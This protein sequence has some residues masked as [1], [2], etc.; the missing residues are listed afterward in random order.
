MRWSTGPG[1]AAA[2][3]A[4]APASAY[5][6]DRLRGTTAATRLSC[7]T[8]AAHIWSHRFVMD[9]MNF[10]MSSFLFYSTTRVT[11]ACVQISGLHDEAHWVRTRPGGWLS[12]H[13]ENQLEATGRVSS[14]DFF[15]LPKNNHKN[16]TP[17]HSSIMS[18]QMFVLRLTHLGSNPSWL[19]PRH[20]PPPAPA[21]VSA[22]HPSAPPPPFPPPTRTSRHLCSAVSWLR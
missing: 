3:C 4:P 9:R 20:P 5:R 14:I 13:G 19:H 10:F 22:P 7:C 6:P 11:A 8:A 16:I 18:Q 2:P 15:F 21:H 17:P 1:S 12:A